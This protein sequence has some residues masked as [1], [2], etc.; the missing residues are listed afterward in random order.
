VKWRADNPTPYGYQQRV[1]RE[2]E[3]TWDFILKGA[4]G[5]GKTMMGLEIGRRTGKPILVLT[6]AKVCR[7][8]ALEV[9]KWFAD[10]TVVRLGGE[11]PSVAWAAE[12]PD[13]VII[14]HP[15][16]PYWRDV[17]IRWVQQ[18]QAT[19]IIDEVHELASPDR[20]DHERDVAGDSIWHRKNNR[21]AAAED[22]CAPARRRI[23]MSATPQRKDRPSLWGVLRTTYGADE[24]PNYGEWKRRYC[25][26]VPGEHGGF[27]YAGPKN[28][29]ELKR[30]ITPRTIFVTKEEL[31]AEI[32]PLVVERRR[33]PEKEQWSHG[34]LKEFKAAARKAAKEGPMA[35]LE[36]R[37]AEAAYKKR[38]YVIEQATAGAT[39]GQNIAIA[40]NRIAEAKFL[41]QAIRKELKTTEGK[42]PV[43]LY[44]GE[45][46]DK[47]RDAA[48]DR[49]MDTSTPGKV[50]IFTHQAGGTG[51]NLDNAHRA[52]IVAPPT[53]PSLFIQLLGRFHRASTRHNVFIEIILADGTIDERISELLLP[54]LDDVNATFDDSEAGNLH[55]VVG[56]QSDEEIQ[57]E[58]L[59]LFGLAG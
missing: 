1:I 19:V 24:V 42:Q 18:N 7:Q 59:A 39:S 3:D 29:Q 26:M 15:V 20:W 31:A 25:K 54:R 14:G 12:R 47:T 34:I 44:H 5:C 11:T 46:T 40:V 32:P 45:Q 9:N 22:I 8:F 13:V 35:M 4:A 41:A 43:Y 6:K 38:K 55:A 52:Y 53:T 33:L 49:F 27:V 16:L 58:L 57:S 37:V 23:G 28:S 48:V 30:F 21:A 10:A 51:L 36:L 56:A 2:A 50:F 17:L